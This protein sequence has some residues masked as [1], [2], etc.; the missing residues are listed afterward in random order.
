MDIEKL[1]VSNIIEVKR[2]KVALHDSPELL[3]IFE[4]ILRCCNSNINKEQ[5]VSRMEL[6]E[7]I[8]PDL[9][10]TDEDDDEF[11]YS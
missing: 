10:S 1:D 4:I 11:Y 5:L 2:I 6:E 8:E 9:S 3:K 7:N